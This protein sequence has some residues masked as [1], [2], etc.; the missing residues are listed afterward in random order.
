M[1]MQPDSMQS[2]E[3]VTD[4]NM[5][6]IVSCQNGERAGMLEQVA[7]GHTKDFVHK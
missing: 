7:P 4:G 5:S 3:S 2:T 1:T 6:P